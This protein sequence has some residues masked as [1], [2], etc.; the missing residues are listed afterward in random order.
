MLNRLCIEEQI[1]LIN[2]VRSPAQ[3]ELL[4]AA[5]ATWVCDSTSGTFSGD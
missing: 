2:I 5:G 4:R 3:A 1:P